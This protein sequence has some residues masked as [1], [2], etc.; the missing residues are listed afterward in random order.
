MTLPEGGKSTPKGLTVEGLDAVDQWSVGFLRDG[1]YKAYAS[2]ARLRQSPQLRT[3]LELP[4]L[5]GQVAISI[6]D[7]LGRRS[8]WAPWRCPPSAT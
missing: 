5:R 6:V 3:M 2:S 4:L 1:V 7:A 8:L